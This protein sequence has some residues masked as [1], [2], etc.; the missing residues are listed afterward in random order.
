[1]PKPC[2]LSTIISCF[3]Q[4]SI[5]VFPGFLWAIMLAPLPLKLLCVQGMPFTPLPVSRLLN[6]LV[7][8]SC[9]DGGHSCWVEKKLVLL[10]ALSGRCKYSLF[11]GCHLFMWFIC[12][13]VCY[14]VEV[15]QYKDGYRVFFYSDS[16]FISCVQFTYPPTLFC[17]GAGGVGKSN[18]A[19]VYIRRHSSQI[20]PG[21]RF[22]SSSEP[23]DLRDVGHSSVFYIVVLGFNNI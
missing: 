11:Q 2:L 7:A 12:S 3:D 8:K 23:R 15:C 13:K 5:N 18:A 4:G 1:M 21:D 19:I 20:R 10:A 9:G 6:I 22:G 16:A 14:E 17:I